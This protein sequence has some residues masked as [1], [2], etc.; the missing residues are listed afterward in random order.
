[1]R[2]LALLAVVL[3]GCAAPEP[4]VDAPAWAERITSPVWSTRKLA[5]RELVLGAGDAELAV[6]LVH[7]AAD[8][9]LRGSRRLMAAA[10]AAD[11]VAAVHTAGEIAVDRSVPLQMRFQVAGS[12]AWQDEAHDIAPQLVEL[13]EA[14]RAKP[15]TPEQAAAGVRLLAL[16]APDQALTVIEEA[17]GAP[18]KPTRKAGATALT[19]APIPGA[20]DTVLALTRRPEVYLRRRGVTALGRYPWEPEAVLRLSEVLATEDDDRVCTRAIEAVE[21]MDP[22]LGTQMLLDRLAA[23]DGCG[24]A[25]QF[26]ILASMR[27]MLRAEPGQPEV[28]AVLRAAVPTAPEPALAGYTAAALGDVKLAAQL[29]PQGAYDGLAEL[30]S[31]TNE[32]LPVRLDAI[33]ALGE[34][35]AVDVTSTLEALLGDVE[36]E[37]EQQRRVLEVLRHSDLM[38][39][40]HGFLAIA[41]TS[42]AEDP[43]LRAL[44]VA[45]LEEA[46]DPHSA[47]RLSEL[48]GAGPASPG[49]RR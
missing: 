2:T 33:D 22:Q 23:D 15:E 49:S 8:A 16:Y 34:L 19:D 9:D 13:A 41:W 17:L 47:V 20:L 14:L 48:G 35:D 36:A 26:V 31:R 46:T 5:Q 12:V 29:P 37:P 40:A 1:M 18:D 43:E 28:R 6:A 3:V 42:D 11:P 25:H 39:P 27:R 24:P 32:P 45:W 44:A 38:D 30:V 4:V 7:F 21:G 10:W